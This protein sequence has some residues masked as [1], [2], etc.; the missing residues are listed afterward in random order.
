MAS[1]DVAQ[2]S[3][4]VV[5][6][7]GGASGIGAALTARLGAAGAQVWIADRQFGVAEELAQRLRDTGARVHAVELD[8]RDP[9]AFATAIAA[10]V[11][12][13][14][15]IDYLF[16][17]AGIGIGGEVDTL[18]LDDWN[19]IIDVNLRGVVHGIQAAY[20]IMIRQ[21]SGHIV[22]TASMAGLV[23]TSAQAGYSA[24]KHAVVALSKTMRVEA[25]TH[26]VRV[27]VLCP[28]VVRTPILSG[29]AYGRNKSV[30]REDLVKLGEALRPMD[31][32]D[33]ADRALR[34]VLR[35]EAII[36][37]PRWWKALWYLERL[38]PALSMRTAAAALKRTREVQ[39]A[40]P[41]Q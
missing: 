27:S 21:G 37:V 15:R 24:T 25:A 17:N 29:G 16:N 22:N 1:K 8:V 33:F 14:G 2:L 39:S 34:A 12:T 19:D 11:Q 6:I 20:P 7:T 30:S 13:A 36:V 23:T 32:D 31:A 18:T 26:G 3:G 40:V 10:T 41:P 5:F 38:S 9:A 35:N 28:G 4:K